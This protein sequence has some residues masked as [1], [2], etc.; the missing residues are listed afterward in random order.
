MVA[1]PGAEVKRRPRLRADGAL[2]R[3]LALGY[4]RAGASVCVC[5]MGWGVGGGGVCVGVYGRVGF[6]WLAGVDRSVVP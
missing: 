5:V 1:N 6:L 3:R 2:I 4:G